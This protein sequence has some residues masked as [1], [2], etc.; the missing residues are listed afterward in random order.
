[1]VKLQTL[2]ILLLT[3]SGTAQ[4]PLEK[5]Y[6]RKQFSTYD[7]LVQSQI[8]RIVQDSKGYLWICTKGGL[9]RFDGLRFQNFVDDQDGERIN[10][11]NIVEEE[12][13]FIVN[14]DSKIWKFT[15]EEENPE[16]WSFE[17]IKIPGEYRFHAQVSIFH[18]EADNSYYIFNAQKDGADIEHFSHFRY[19]PDRKTIQPL[20][21][22]NQPVILSFS[23]KH[24]RYWLSPD[25]IFSFRNGE[26]QSQPLPW[27]FD[28][29]ALSP[30][31]TTIYGYQQSTKTIFRIDKDFR[32]STPIFKNISIIRWEPTNFIIN[33]SGQFIYLNENRQV[34]VISNS[35]PEIIISATNPRTLFCGRENNLWIGTEEGLFNMFQL[36]FEQYVF[37]ITQSTDNVWSLV[38]A[39]DSTMWF[40]GFLTGVWTLDKKEHI[41]VYKSMEFNLPEPLRSEFNNIYMGG[42]RDKEGRIYIPSSSGLLNVDK[43]R[44]KY[45]RTT[46]G[47]LSV[48]DDTIHNQLIIGRINGLEIMEKGSWKIRSDIHCKHNIISTCI[49][50]DG[51]VI[52]GSFRKQFVLDGDSLK[53]YLSLKNLGVISMV[54]DFR[55]N[56]WK[57]TPVGLYLDDGKTETEILPGEIK[58][59][60]S[61]VFIK[62]PWLMAATV[63]N[64]YLMN[65]D[66][67][68]RNSSASA[69]KFGV[70]NGY[71][72][73]DGGQNGFCEDNEGKMWYTVT[74]KV[75]RFS[76]DSLARHFSNYLPIPHFASISYSKNSIDWLRV[77]QDDTSMLVCD[78]L[79]NSIRFTMYAI[80]ETRPDKIIYQYRLKGMSNEWS[81]PTRVTQQSFTNLRPGRYRIE[82]RSSLDGEH[83]SEF[84]NSRE[85]RIKSAWWQKWWAYF[86]AI[87]LF[88]SVIASL[89]FYSLKWRHKKMIRKITEQKRLN[90][91]RLQSVRSKNIPHFSGNALANIEHFIFNAD[92]RRANKFL[93]KYSR[94]MNITLRDADKACRSIEEELEYVSLYLELEKMRFEDNLE[95]SIVVSSDVNQQKDLPNMLMQTWVEN[96]IKHGIR[97]KEGIGRILVT[98]A[99]NDSGGILVSVQDNGIGRTKA[100]ELGTTGTGQG[101]KILAEQI[102]I[103]NL[104]NAM[105]IVVNTCD[106]FSEEGMAEGTRFEMTIPFEY[107]F[108]F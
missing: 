90:E 108:D 31:D 29:Y 56:I 92:L 78:H 80:S 103:Y 100:K 64:M 71:I 106:L 1:M 68:Y 9:S 73:M 88:G 93:T 20:P 52:A 4:P 22:A 98:I 58:G 87:L 8:N 28:S 95:Y 66:S 84:V 86:I 47:P 38:C 54:K 91:L 40:G 69:F 23:N 27:K 94:L 25:H 24:I 16:I 15:Y 105:K 81:Q 42:V 70:E 12:K 5:H 76:P 102:A 72:A 51:K 83:W 57:G 85:I 43:K 74:D 107:N 36:G 65:L 17:D 49:N 75:L 32:N 96:A 30:T 77:A 99:N 59:S 45:I 7:G 61:S 89:V 2:I 53:P 46:L 14:S 6:S 21:I 82:I 19:D 79:Y 33:R 67:F 37:N 97:H 35:K 26:F 50:R 13:G 55:G 11:Q 3:L 34:C 44:L 39:P 48:Y 18:N 104:I 63:K 60:I 62:K 41:R 10:I 101:L